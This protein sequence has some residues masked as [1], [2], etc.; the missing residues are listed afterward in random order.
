MSNA[1][2][3][4]EMSDQDT[5]LIATFLTAL[6]GQQPQVPYPLLPVETKDT[7]RPKP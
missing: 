5:K 7:P 3:G 6:T 4:S 1:Q 2:L